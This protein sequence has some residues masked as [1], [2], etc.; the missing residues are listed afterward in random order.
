MDREFE[1][2]LGCNTVNRMYITP[3]GDVLVCPYVH[4]KIGNV[5]EQ[6]LKEISE[7]G[8][9][10]K[11]FKNHSDLCLAG[12]DTEFIKKFMT[13]EGQTIFNPSKAEDILQKS[14]AESTKRGWEE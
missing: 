8:F 5:Y 2:V 4:V 7:Y 10:I 9:S 1:D 11:Y 6:S 12:E 13:R 3:L 14:G